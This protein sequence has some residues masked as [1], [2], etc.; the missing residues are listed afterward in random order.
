[1]PVKTCRCFAVI[2]ARPEMHALLER[3][4]T[5]GQFQYTYSYVFC[6]RAI[7]AI[8]AAEHGRPSD[9]VPYHL[10]VNSLHAAN[11]GTRPELEAVGAYCARHYFKL[12]SRPDSPESEIYNPCRWYSDIRQR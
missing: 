6:G 9:L 1:M 12:Q 11:Y 4:C 3:K 8:R 7:A 2:V 10:T 5:C